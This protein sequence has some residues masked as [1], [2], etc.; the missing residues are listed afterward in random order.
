MNLLNTFCMKRNLKFKD[1]NENFFIFGKK[2][3]NNSNINEL[4]KL[5]NSE[6]VIFLTNR[7]FSIFK[8]KLLKYF[9][10]YKILYLSYKNK[11]DIIHNLN[12]LNLFIK[13]I[14]NNDKHEFMNYYNLK[15]LKM[16][17]FLE[18]NIEPN[19]L[20]K[21]ILFSKEELYLP[22]DTY[23]IKK[24]EYK[25]R[26]FCQIAEKMGA[27]K[28]TIKYHS[29]NK[30]KI[31]NNGYLNTL[32]QIIGGKHELETKTDGTVKLT[33]DYNNNYYNLNLNKFYINELVEKENEFFITKEDFQSDIDMKFLIDARCI[34]LIKKY[35]TNIVINKINAL[36]EKIIMKAHKFGLNMQ[37]KNKNS[38]SNEINIVINFLNI[39]DKP[40]CIDGFNIYN[41]KEGFIHLSNIIKIKTDNILKKYEYEILKNKDKND[42]E[43][44][45][46]LRLFNAR[47]E[48][49]KKDEFYKIYNFL[50]SHLKGLERNNFSID[51]KYNK[52]KNELLCFHEI[53]LSFKQPEI[54]IIFYNYFKNNLYYEKF[55]ILRNVILIGIPHENLPTKLNFVCQQ[56]HFIYNY[57]IKFIVEIKEII[58]NIESKLSIQRNTILDLF[59]QLKSSIKYN[60]ILHD[61]EY[62]FSIIYIFTDE[63]FDILL[64][65][66]IEKKDLFD[67]LIKIFEEYIKNYNNTLNDYE[68]Q[69]MKILWRLICE[70][71]NLN[72]LIFNEINMENFMIE[73]KSFFY[74]NKNVDIKN[75]Y[76]KYR[77]F[78]TYEESTLFI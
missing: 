71:L 26:T 32:G 70:D 40:E 54:E 23:T 73:F 45:L 47:I 67:K 37:I 64:L 69:F 38:L 36:E 13:N 57:K 29:N 49:E 72:E 43:S 55:E 1:Y 58:K 75:N 39:Y 18:N 35:D 14:E 4:I 3:E 68:I 48:I 5:L 9:D 60:D 46:C 76:N 53:F 63:L 17:Y 44:K 22:F 33:F 27:E 11:D 24:M 59:K 61:N 7:F 65:E 66:K 2:E 41:L 25:L 6:Y 50:K 21:K 74:S 52:L 62:Y 20:Y 10:K 12:I 77:L 34:N 51:I 78:I 15:N 31:K 42:I 16:L 30:N 8:K 56:Y 28:I 19:T